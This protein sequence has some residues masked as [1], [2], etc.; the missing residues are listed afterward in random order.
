VRVQRPFDLACFLLQG[1]DEWTLDKIRIAMD[2][3]PE[4][5][6]GREYLEEHE[7]DPRPLKVIT[8][9]DVTPRVPVYIIYYTAYPDPETGVVN[10]Y[11]DLYGYD[12]VIRRKMGEYLVDSL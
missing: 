11:P 5:E 9:R 8:Y 3:K 12:K 2:M 10:Y 1:A 7:E 6:K 4:T